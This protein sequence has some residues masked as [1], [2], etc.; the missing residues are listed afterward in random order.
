LHGLQPLERRRRRPEGQSSCSDYLQVGLYNPSVL[1]ALKTQLKKSAFLAAFLRYSLLPTSNSFSMAIVDLNHVQ[2][3]A[4]PSN[5]FLYKQCT[6]SSQSTGRSIC[7]NSSRNQL[8]PLHKADRIFKHN[9][10][11]KSAITA[12]RH[13]GDDF[14]AGAQGT[15]RRDSQ[16][17]VRIADHHKDSTNCNDKADDDIPSIEEILG[18]NKPALDTSRSHVG[19]K[20][21]RLDN[22]AGD[23]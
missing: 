3:W 17:V 5:L 23:S 20:Q 15:I 13:Q 21:S 11:S 4:P 6:T 16:N 8:A 7:T 22:G 9:D 10:Q 1:P 2:F 14:V 18:L 19:L 12:A